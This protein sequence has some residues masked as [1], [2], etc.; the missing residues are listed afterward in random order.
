MI[1]I[2][3]YGPGYISHRFLEGMKDVKGAKVTAFCTRNKDRVREYAAEYGIQKLLSREE[4]FLDK[5][6]DAVYMATPTL[7][8]YELIRECLLNGKH[9]LSEKPMVAT[10]DQVNELHGIADEK[11]LMLMEAQKC[12]YVPMFAKITEWLKEERIGKV[13]RAEADFSRP[14]GIPD[15]YYREA[16]PGKGAVY[17]IGCYALSE[18]LGLFGYDYDN[19][20]VSNRYRFEVPEESV[21]NI[22]L[23]NGIQLT[24][25]CSQIRWGTNDLRITGEKG[26]IICHEFWKSHDCTLITEDKTEEVHFDFNSEF[27]F[28]T[29]HFIDCINLGLTSSPINTPELCRQVTAIMEKYG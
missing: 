7:N 25:T 9:V 12:L 11:G 21:I 18:L 10:V 19:V 23:K 22:H 29:Q 24:A 20:D 8:H 28:E 15:D 14:H 3:V 6:I 4:L 17:D 13:I 1:N 27:T 26:T 5:D 16:K 2:A